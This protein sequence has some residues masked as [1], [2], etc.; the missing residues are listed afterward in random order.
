MTGAGLENYLQLRAKVDDLCKG[1]A[2]QLGDALVCSRGCDSCCQLITVFPVEAAAIAAA[3]EQLTEAERDV[4]KVRIRQAAPEGC[5][6]LF[7]GECLVYAVRPIICRTHGLPV[8]VKEEQGGRVDV[9]PL[10]CQGMKSI[11][12]SAV[13]ELE[14]LNTLLAAVNAL[15]LKELDEAPSGERVTI[16]QALERLL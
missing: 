11:P 15:Y 2:I 4:L 6:L 10:N 12:G 9:C 14:R 1:I 16:L 8:L 5:P 7:K 13:I 3:V